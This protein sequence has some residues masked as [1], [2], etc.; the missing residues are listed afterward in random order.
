MYIL[1]IVGKYIYIFIFILEEMIWK[2]ILQ[3]QLLLV[4]LASNLIIKDKKKLL[5]R[6]RINN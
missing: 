6:T 4:L 5:K 1:F 3:A 2:L